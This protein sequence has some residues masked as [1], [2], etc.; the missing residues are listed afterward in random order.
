MSWKKQPQ[1]SQ[2]EL[3]V[4]CATC[5]TAAL[6]APMDMFICVGFGFAVLSKN[7]VTVYDGEEALQQ[8]QEPWTVREAEE[9]AKND[10]DHDWRIVKHGPLHGETFQRH[11]PGCWVCIESNQGFA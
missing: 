9:L 4:G 11:G 10:P 3:H 5:S 7:G 2:N 1:I 6:K 8:E